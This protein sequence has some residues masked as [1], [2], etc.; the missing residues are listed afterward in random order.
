M[1]TIGKVLDFIP[2]KDR[3]RIVT[4]SGGATH[5]IRS[6]ASLSFVAESHYATVFFSSA[7]NVRA[8]VSSSV[9]QEFDV[10]A[11]AL[12]IVPAGGEPMTV[13]PSKKESV[14]VVITPSAMA[15]L[16]EGEYDGKIFEPRPMMATAIDPQALHLAS[17]LRSEL[18]E[19][20]A[21]NE[22]YVDS[23][24]TF[25]G[26]HLLRNYSGAENETIDARGALSPSNM[27]RIRE[28]LAENFTRKL[29]VADLAAVCELSPRHFIQAFAKSFGKQPH[30]YLMGLRLDFA[31]QLLIEGKLTVTEV[32]LLSGFASQSHLTFTLKKHCGL[33]PMQ[34]REGK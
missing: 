5:S 33:T 13:W 28:F 7:K 23:I 24:I 30:Q 2:D 6:G 32:A 9:A 34:L 31:R 11:G 16:S 1:K 4:V 27:R 18:T 17:L 15:A 20:P 3:S 26:I 21:P 14:A 12:G 29:L 10:P 25:F 8:S 22:L 19:R